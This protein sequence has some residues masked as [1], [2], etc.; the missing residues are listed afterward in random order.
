MEEKTNKSNW[1]HNTPPLDHYSL[2]MIDEYLESIGYSVV[3]SEDELSVKHTQG[4]WTYGVIDSEI[5]GI[6]CK[7]VQDRAKSFGVDYEENGEIAQCWQDFH[8]GKILPESEM[9]ANAKLMAAAPELLSLLQDVLE[10]FEKNW[11]NAPWV[12]KVKEVIKKATE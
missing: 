10:V 9:M 6:F 4:E 12:L 7:T 8:N 2:E 11:P 5:G 1:Q 3:K